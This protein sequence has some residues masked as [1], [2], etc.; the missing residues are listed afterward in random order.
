M[1]VIRLFRGVTVELE[2]SRAH[3]LLTLLLLIML[4]F[5]LQQILQTREI[6]SRATRLLNITSIIT[7][8][9]IIRMLTM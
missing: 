4:Q 5:L 2:Q 1:V 7:I 6:V 3:L 8:F 9:Q